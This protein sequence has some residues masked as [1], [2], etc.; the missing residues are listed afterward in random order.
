MTCAAPAYCVE[1]APPQWR[2]KMVGIYNWSVLCRIR[3]EDMR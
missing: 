2:G 3:S 1:C